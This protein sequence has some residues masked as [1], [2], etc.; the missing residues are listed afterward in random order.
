MKHGGFR[1]G[2]GRKAMGVTKKV[3]IT[4]FKEQW[5]KIDKE[6]GEGSYS[7]YFRELVE[8][9]DNLMSDVDEIIRQGEKD[10]E[11]N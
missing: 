8:D 4:L 3:S 7:A 5:D 2:A 1:E 10:Q 9:M 6:K 11:G